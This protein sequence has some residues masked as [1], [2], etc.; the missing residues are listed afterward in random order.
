M[1]T[2]PTYVHLNVYGY[3]NYYGDVD[4]DVI[5]DRLHPNTAAPNYINMSAPPHPHIA[6][7]LTVDH[8][9]LMWTFE[10]RKQSAVGTIMY[11]LLL[12]VPVITG[13]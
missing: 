13:A 7:T 3:D 6:W 9:D 1:S 2:W 8:A 10:P 4:G 11:A 5:F 12:A